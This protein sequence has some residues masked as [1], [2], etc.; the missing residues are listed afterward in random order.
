MPFSLHFCG[1]LGLLHAHLY[2]PCSLHLVATSLKQTP[3]L[4]PQNLWIA[5]QPLARL[6]A[7]TEITPLVKKWILGA[8]PS[9]LTTILSIAVGLWLLCAHFGIGVT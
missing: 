5:T 4:L 7:M 9:Q 6:L 8:K 3:F 1:S 2:A